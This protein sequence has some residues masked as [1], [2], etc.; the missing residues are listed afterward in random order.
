MIARGYEVVNP[1]KLDLDDYIEHSGDRTTGKG[2][3]PIQRARFLKR[4]FYFLAQCDGIILLEGW[5]A[6]IGANAELAA[7]IIMGLDIY[8]FT[9]SGVPIHT[10]WLLPS[11]GTVTEHMS[12][13]LTAKHDFWA[14]ADEEARK[15]SLTKEGP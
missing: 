7:A 14:A 5:R 2:V 1:S 3:K 11:M 13:V 4:D 6:S 15:A 8:S 12:E 9:M 10:P